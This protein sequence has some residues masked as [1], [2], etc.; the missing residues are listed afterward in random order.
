MRTL[1]LGLACGM[2]MALGFVLATAADADDAKKAAGKAA[3]MISLKVDL[4]LP[5]SD[6]DATP[7][8]GSLSMAESQTDVHSR[9]RSTSE[10][11][12]Y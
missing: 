1:R 8:P 6:S 5:T 10:P 11:P 12:A 7:L 4:A 2:A 9:P 3:G